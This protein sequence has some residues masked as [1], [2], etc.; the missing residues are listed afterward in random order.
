VQIPAELERQFVVIEHELPDREQLAAIARS[1][2]AEPGE[3]PE[4]HAF[5]A[6]VEAAGGL[7]RLEAEGAFALSL[8][9][10]GRVEP[11]PL[12]ELKSSQ[13]KKSALLSL[14][15]GGEDRLDAHPDCLLDE[16]KRGNSIFFDWHI[17]MRLFP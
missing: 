10:H 16:M 11:G 4:G 15:R 13:L 3:L 17:R 9:R 6:V 8:V 5:E 7:T 14:H 1:V 12:W 2:A